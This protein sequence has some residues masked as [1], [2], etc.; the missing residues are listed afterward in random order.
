[1]ISYN[2]RGNKICVSFP[3]MVFI[4]LLSQFDTTGLLIISFLAILFH[5]LGHLLII[6]FLGIK[7]FKLIFILGSVKV[8]I[9][10]ILPQNKMALIAL[11]GPLINLILTIFIL[12]ENYYLAYFGACNIIVFLFN[13]LPIKQLDGGDILKYLLKLLFKN[14]SEKAFNLLSLIFILLFTAFC[15]TFFIIKYYN[16]TL[17]IVGIYLIIMS[18][19]KV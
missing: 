12:F 3:F 14:Y 2:L 7:N 17:L 16:P 6:K 8:V 10:E 13:M 5:E 18:I 4:T 9:K 11:G 15:G 19:K 1:M